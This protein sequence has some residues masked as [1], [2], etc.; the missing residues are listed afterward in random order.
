MHVR[1]GCKAMLLAGGTHFYLLQDSPGP[2][3]QGLWEVRGLLGFCLCSQGLWETVTKNPP[4][5]PDPQDPPPLV[6]TA[7]RPSPEPWMLRSCQADCPKVTRASSSQP[8]H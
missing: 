2:S 4:P 8:S 5:I 6:P 7:L 1:F 3:A